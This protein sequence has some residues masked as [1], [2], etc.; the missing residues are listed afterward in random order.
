MG[1]VVVGILAI[2][3]IWMVWWAIGQLSHQK[4]LEAWIEARRAEGWV[5]DVAELDTVGFPSRFDTTLTEV[6]LADPATGVAWAAP[7]VQFLSLAYRPT[8]VIAVLPNEHR[9]STPLQTLTISHSEAKASLFLKPSTSLALSRARLVIDTL[10]IASNRGWEATLREG[11]FAAE[12]IDTD[13]TYRLGVEVL[14]LRPSEDVRALLDPAGILPEAVQSLKL[15]ATLGF[16]APWDR[17]ALEDARP[18]VTALDLANLSARWGEVTFRAAGEL[19]VD[20]DG[21]PKGRI[22][23]KAVEWRQMLQMAVNAGALPEAFVTTAE[24]GLGLLA[25]L[26]GDPDTIDVPLTF[27]NGRMSLGPIPLGPAPLIVIR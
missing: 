2:F 25:S 4:G 16:D 26:S 3:G 8:E 13:N 24:S 7:F 20:T 27:D 18:Q 9:F 19:D 5:A 14:E 6:N 17:Y 11:R 21:V 12:E 15:D 10:D 22:T 1:R 23:I